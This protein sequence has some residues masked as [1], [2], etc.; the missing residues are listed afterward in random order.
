MT[1][2]QAYLLLYFQ[3]DLNTIFQFLIEDNHQ[4][5]TAHVQGRQV[6]QVQRQSTWCLQL[7]AFPA[8]AWTHLREPAVRTA[9]SLSTY[10]KSH[11]QPT[12]GA[13]A[14]RVRMLAHHFSEVA[15]SWFID[16]IW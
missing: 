15:D 6:G 13:P 4:Q 14:G 9:H 5:F 1:K 3:A 11:F 10:S 8:E 2:L 16:Y 12:L 7:T